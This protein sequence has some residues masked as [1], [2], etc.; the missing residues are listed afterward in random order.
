VK[1]IS[2]LGKGLLKINFSL[3]SHSSVEYHKISKGVLSAMSDPQ[4][5]RQFKRFL[6]PVAHYKGKTEKNISGISDV[7]DVSHSG[8]R[9]L[10]SVALKKGTLLSFRINVP[11]VL[12]FVCEGE[13][14]WD[15]AASG[16]MYWLG[17]C[18]TE[19]N[20][21]DKMKLLDYAYDHWLETMKTDP[22]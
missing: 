4:E 18:F 11:N 3:S 15:E 12:D 5:K 10:S 17:L 9:I 6:L 22:T 8:L 19:I 2:G 16:E 1:S 7:W 14:R 13:V 20:P 21:A